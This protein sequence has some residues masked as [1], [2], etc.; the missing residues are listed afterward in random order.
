MLGIAVLVPS[1]RIFESICNV[2]FLLPV[3]ISIKIKNRKFELLVTSGI[4]HIERKARYFMA[5][6]RACNV[7]VRWL[8]RSNYSDRRTGGLCNGEIY[9]ERSE[10][11]DGGTKTHVRAH[12]QKDGSN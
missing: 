2:P 12:T 4:D 1:R 7:T 10:R 11:T 3:L 6:C 8:V 5:L 9:G